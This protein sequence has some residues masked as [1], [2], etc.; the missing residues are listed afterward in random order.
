MSNSKHVA[1]TGL[2][3]LAT[4][5]GIAVGSLLIAGAFGHFAAIWDRLAESRLALLTPG[6]LLAL[7][8]SINLLLTLAIW[9]GK[10][11]SVVLAL[12]ANTIAAGYFASLLYSGV[13]NH[14]IGLFLA[15]TSSYMLVLGA[16]CMGLTWPARSA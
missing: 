11:W 3:H 1:A 13:E 9:R 15:V 8:G 12:L 4:V 7:T 5:G 16:I 14:P 10:R 6:V 2:N